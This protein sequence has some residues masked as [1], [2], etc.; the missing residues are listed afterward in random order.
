MVK[1]SRRSLDDPAEDVQNIFGRPVYK[2]VLEKKKP[3]L[4]IPEKVTINT[5]KIRDIII[6]EKNDLFYRNYVLNL[7]MDSFK[8]LLNPYIKLV[9][10]K[11]KDSYPNIPIFDN[12]LN[13]N[14]KFKDWLRNQRLRLDDINQ[15]L[16]DNILILIDIIE[17][18]NELLK[19]IIYLI[20]RQNMD[21]VAI[22]QRVDIP[23]EI[24]EVIYD[25]MGVIKDEK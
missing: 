19:F 25:E 15:Q 8:D 9:K 20:F 10:R 6:K 23:I 22:A 21:L 5:S 4:K 18:N 16:F 24:I 12:G 1:R 3:S 13:F 17:R 7:N 11:F 14:G 2:R